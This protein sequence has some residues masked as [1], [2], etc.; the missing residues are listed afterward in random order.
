MKIFVLDVELARQSVLLA[1][2]LK[3]MVEKEESTRINVL[4]VVLV[5]VLALLSVSLQL[6]N[7]KLINEGSRN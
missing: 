5:Q 4:I 2:F 7:I 1:A 6:N 3:L